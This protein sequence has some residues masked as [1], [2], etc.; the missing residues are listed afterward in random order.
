MKVA[1][2]GLILK[3]WLAQGERSPAIPFG[4]MRR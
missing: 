2:G 4:S 1:A 3:G